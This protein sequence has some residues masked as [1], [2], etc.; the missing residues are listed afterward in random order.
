MTEV[1]MQ[2]KVKRLATTKCKFSKNRNGSKT[3]P[4]LTR[5]TGASL[6]EAGLL[7]SLIVVVSI[8]SIRGTGRDVTCTFLRADWTYEAKVTV[9]LFGNPPDT[10]D[11][12]WKMV[13]D[14]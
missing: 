3:R 5:E 11:P 1:D 9:A 12:C 6:V 4:R 2:L 14:D 10:S 7:V 13:L 8:I